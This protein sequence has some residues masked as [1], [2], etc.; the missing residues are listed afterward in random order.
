[1]RRFVLRAGGQ[2]SGGQR[3]RIVMP[4]QGQPGQ[5][6]GQGQGQGSE[7]DSPGQEGQPGQGQGQGQGAGGQGDGQGQSDELV[8]EMRPGGQ[9]ADAILEMP[10]MGGGQ[11]RPGQGGGNEPGSSQYGTDHHPDSM[12][13]ATELDSSGEMSRVDGAESDGATRSQVIRGASASGFAGR[14][15][16]NVHADYAD[17]AEEILQREDV[18]A[19]YRYYVRR[20][21]QLIRPREETSP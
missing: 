21:F 6:G 11:Q 16:R 4:G 1:M 10:G 14:G 17:H 9:G 20:Y 8:L 2:G 12:A 18:P 15:Y 3:V 19:G 13:S 7:G 5:G